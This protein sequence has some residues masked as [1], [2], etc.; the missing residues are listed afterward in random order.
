M[1]Y[2]TDRLAPRES[3]CANLNTEGAMD[4]IRVGDGCIPFVVQSAQA[5]DELP[6]P[7]FLVGSVGNR[8][9]WKIWYSRHDRYRVGT[10]TVSG[11]K[12]REN[13]EDV[14]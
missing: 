11:T 8:V 3:V 14:T 13:G 5:A 6:Q 2:E 12:R 1:R 4:A 7:L 9:S 10:A